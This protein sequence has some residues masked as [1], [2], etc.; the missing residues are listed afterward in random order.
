[1]PDSSGR[2]R[3]IRRPLH[4]P[5][6]HFPVGAYVFAA[7][8]DLVSLGGGAR[9]AWAR[10]LYHAGT[11]VLIAGTA[12]CLV[13]MATGFT[14]LIRFL[15]G[16]RPALRTVSAHICVMAAVFMIGIGDLAWR[17]SDYGRAVTPPGI[18]ACSVAAAIGVCAG[19]F[20]GGELVF[21]HG[22]AVQPGGG[23]AADPGR[24]VRARRLT[25]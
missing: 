7:G 13:T 6:T 23:R 12:L 17:I 16:T 15:P 25:S 19:G 20:I 5:F 11:F 4:P 24:D 1:M 3:R 22:I 9:H 14:D 8:F 10:E 21:R 2:S 18:A